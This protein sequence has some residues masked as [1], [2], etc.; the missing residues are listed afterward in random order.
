[1]RKWLLQKRTDLKFTQEDVA[2]KAGIARTTYASIE[3]GLRNPSVA[4]AKKIG[5][6]LDFEWTIFFEQE[7]HESCHETQSKK[8]I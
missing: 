3:Q 2:D 4:V 6:V 5:T 8:A 1:M 7:C